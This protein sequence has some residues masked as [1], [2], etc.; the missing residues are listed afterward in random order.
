MG[1]E[2]TDNH[3]QCF[4]KGGGLLRVSRAP[5]SILRAPEFKTR[6]TCTCMASDVFPPPLKFTV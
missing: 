5:E 1:H 4:G 3:R 6:G 2:R